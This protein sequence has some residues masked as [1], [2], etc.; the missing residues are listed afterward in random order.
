MHK[1]C[2]PLHTI[3]LALSLGIIW[4]FAVFIMG[5]LAM[6]LNYGTGA[7][8][9]MGSN[10]YL[11]Y[12]PSFLGSIIGSLWAFSDAF[13]GGVLLGWLYNKISSRCSDKCDHK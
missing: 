3:S 10:Y 8:A 4:A 13:L 7:V 11:G 12:A 1:N 9:F 6:F 2:Q 5:M